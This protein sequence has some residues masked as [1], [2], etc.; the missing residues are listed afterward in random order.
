MSHEPALQKT[1]LFHDARHISCGDLSWHGA[2]GTRLPVA[3]PPGPE[4]AA[5]AHSGAVPR[6]IRLVAQQA[7][8]SAPA[9]TP[10]YRP[11]GSAGRPCI[12]L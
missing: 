12:D 2:G 8:K 11:T 7:E 10:P 5:L 9:S 6:G 4:V 3:G 1:Y